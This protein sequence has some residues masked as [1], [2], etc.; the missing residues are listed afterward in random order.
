MRSLWKIY[1]CVGL[2]DKV[3]SRSNNIQMMCDVTAFT[4]FTQFISGTY[5][6]WN[7]LMWAQ[8]GKDSKIQ[9]SNGEVKDENHMWGYVLTCSIKNLIKIFK[10]VII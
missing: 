7:K 9:L 3:H 6:N 5:G 1:V 4:Y 2:P 8:G 10:Y